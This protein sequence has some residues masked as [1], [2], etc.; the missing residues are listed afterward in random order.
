MANVSFVTFEFAEFI[1]GQAK[2]ANCLDIVAE[3]S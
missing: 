3:T 1:H 2:N